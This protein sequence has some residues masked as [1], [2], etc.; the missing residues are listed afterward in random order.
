MSEITHPY[1]DDSAASIYDEEKVMEKR[2]I[3]AADD[4]RRA[5]RDAI[6]KKAF[7]YQLK[8]TY[9]VRLFAEEATTAGLKRTE[10][11]RSAMYREVYATERMAWILAEREYE[12]SKDYLRSLMAVLNSLQTRAKLIQ[13]S[14]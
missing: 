1:A 12:V 14:P 7:Y 5:G 9:L 10:V 3:E 13:F 11:Q 6:Q 4:C 2:V 8:H